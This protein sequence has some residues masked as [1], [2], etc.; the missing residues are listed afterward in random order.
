MCGAPLPAIRHSSKPWNWAG[1][2]AT[3]W[4][5]SRAAD[6]KDK[7]VVLDSDHVT[8]LEWANDEAA[9]RLRARVV[10]IP[11]HE[12]ATT[13]VSYEE[14]SRGWL[15]YL[16]RARTIPQQIEAYRRLKRHLDVYRRI[17]VL[18]FDDRAAA[19]FQRLQAMRLRVGTL[20]LRIAATVLANGARLLTRNLADFRRVPGLTAED[21]TV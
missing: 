11:Q 10:Q 6:G 18:D 19:E 14:Q 13:I 1:D 2:T 8:L 4:G 15:A 17:A 9:H 16:S 12:R 20:D 3:H 7:M 5:Q 21:W